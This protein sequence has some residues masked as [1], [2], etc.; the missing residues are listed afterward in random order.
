M[1]YQFK[2]LSHVCRIQPELRP[3]EPELFVYQL[4]QIGRPRMCDFLA[5]E[6]SMA[7][8]PGCIEG[9]CGFIRCCHVGAMLMFCLRD[10]LLRG[11]IPFHVRLGRYII[12][13]QETHLRNRLGMANYFSLRSTIKDQE[14]NDAWGRSKRY[15]RCVAD[16]PLRPES[17]SRPAPHLQTSA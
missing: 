2:K 5:K 14:E 1:L 3:V 17:R 9:H 7:V 12:L 6:I 8:E 11:S 13:Y 10:S 16:V 15:I 4:V